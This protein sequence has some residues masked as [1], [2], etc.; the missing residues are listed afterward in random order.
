MKT[1]L[2][3]VIFMSFIT[4]IGCNSD[5]SSDENAAV[6][7]TAIEFSLKNNEGEDLLNPENP[8]AIN[9][10][11]I[12]LFY[13]INGEVQEVY[14]ANMQNPRNFM[15]FYHEIKQNYVIRVFQNSSET[16]QS[17]IT[18]IQWDGEDTDTLQAE[19]RRETGLI[20]VTKTWLN[21]NLIW[22][23]NSGTEAYY[24]LVK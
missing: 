19:Y 21:D 20:Q 10:S 18:Y 6:V 16:E 11:G 7:D 9:Q 5:D 8:N 17:P 12:K 2:N 3:I 1:I 15:I 23:I 14:D 24:E 4:T 13:L 22:D